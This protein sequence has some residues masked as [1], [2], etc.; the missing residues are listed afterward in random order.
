MPVNLKQKLTNSSNFFKL[1][2]N[3]YSYYYYY[4]DICLMA[5]FPG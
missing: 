1:T 5:F 4:Y 2:K 3:L